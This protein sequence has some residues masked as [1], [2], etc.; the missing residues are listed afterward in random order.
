MSDTSRIDYIVK[1]SSPLQGTL[2]VPG[3]KS[4]SHRALMLAAIADGKTRIHGFLEGEDTLATMAVLK[5]MGVI[6]E[7]EQAGNISVNGVG[8]HGLKAPAK[9]LYFG[10][11]GTSVRLMAGLL[12]GQ[13]FDTSLTGDPSLTGRPMRRITLPLQQMQADI[14]CSH[15]GTL[16]IVIH[17][18]RKLQAINYDLPVAS[19]QLK[20]SILLAGL[21]AEGTTCIVEPAITRDH[22]ERMLGYFGCPVVKNGGRICISAHKLKSRD[23]EIPGDISSA[24]FFIVAACIREGSELL[25]ENIG[26]NP[27]RNA[28]ITILKLMGA[29]IDLENERETCGEP[30]ADI[31]VKYSRLQGIDIPE[32]LVPIAIDEFPAILVAAAYANG[33]TSLTGAA[34]LRVKES[35]R[36]M[37]ME[38]GLRS[39]GIE[40]ESREDGMTVTGGKPAGATINSFKDH[41]IAMAFTIAGLASSD[42]ITVQDCENVNTSFPGFTDRLQQFGTKVETTVRADG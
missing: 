14:E 23:L 8:L 38:K 31:R 37:A 2:T 27:T 25:L 33:R 15:T 28:V 20:S 10:N 42:R 11:S 40:V 13:K 26:V 4:I 35:D 39:L 29:S 12:A 16:P 18:G 24:A 34:E 30:V 7:R 32:D 22:T 19:A 3:D 36:I 17:G 6:I 5:E 21:Y 1:S 41:R 9:P